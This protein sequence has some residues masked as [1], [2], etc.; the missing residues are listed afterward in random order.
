MT[1]EQHEVTVG[2]SARFFHPLTMGVMHCGRVTKLGE[3]LVQVKFDIDGKKHW[4]FP[5]FIGKDNS[6]FPT[7]ENRKV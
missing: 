4:T 1:T 2:M 3:K 6:D 7:N 5:D